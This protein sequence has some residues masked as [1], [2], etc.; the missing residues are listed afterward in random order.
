ME[1]RYL[2]RGKRI[3]NGE[4]AEG[5]LIT[6]ETD[7][8]KF[9]IGYVLGTDEDGSPHDLDAVQIDPSTICWGTGL[10]DKSGR[11]VWEHDVLMAH[12][13]KEYPDDITYTTVLWRDF[14]FV[15]QENGSVEPDGL[16]ENSFDEF[17]VVG[18]T[19]DNPELLEE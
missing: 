16:D 4:W 17:E 11:L 10:G 15:T 9:F 14:R 7:D 12:L 13:D 6:D 1:N 5:H 2:C 8:S 3:D 19:I 18:N